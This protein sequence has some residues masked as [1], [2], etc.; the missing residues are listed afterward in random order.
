MDITVHSGNLPIYVSTGGS[1]DQT[2]TATGRRLIDLTQ[3]GIELS[4]GAWDTAVHENCLALASQ[5]PVLLHNYFPVPRNPFVLNLSATSPEA[6]Q[7]A[8]QHCEQAIAL[9]GEAGAHVFAVHAGFLADVPVNQLGKRIDRTPLADREQSLRQMGEVLSG[10]ADVADRRG[11]RLLV[12]NHALSPGNLA[13]FGENFL[14]LVDPDEIREF[15]VH[16]DG[17]VGLLLDVGHLRTS[18]EALAFDPVAALRDLDPIV[19]AYHLSDNDGTSDEHAALSDSSWFL[20]HISSG[21][22]A[23][24]VEIHDPNLDSWVASADLLAR[25]LQRTSCERTGPEG[26]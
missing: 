11:V 18:A 10:L 24:T 2:G 9:S 26:G 23:Y 3:W 7:V 13:S 21:K 22:L 12:E 1:R 17:R 4:G 8:V 15:T 6:L 20:P 16:M 25:W 14:L 5:R 19:E